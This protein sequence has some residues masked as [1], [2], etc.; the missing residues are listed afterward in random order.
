MIRCDNS[1]PR[2]QRITLQSEMCAFQ[3]YFQSYLIAFIVLSSKFLKIMPDLGWNFSS[4]MW[5][6]CIS[7][8][9]LKNKISVSGLS[10]SKVFLSKGQLQVWWQYPKK[11]QADHLYPHLPFISKC[12]KT[13]CNVS[14]RWLL[15]R[16]LLIRPSFMERGVMKVTTRKREVKWNRMTSSFLVDK[17]CVRQ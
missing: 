1:T 8:R 15:F 3:P 7:L 4:D 10:S 17:Y 13:Y 12:I 16:D 11:L 9:K 6:V 2:N 14:K 5:N